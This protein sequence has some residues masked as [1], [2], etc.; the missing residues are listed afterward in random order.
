MEEKM[1]GERIEGKI[2]SREGDV[3]EYPLRFFYD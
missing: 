1:A 2:T 3:K